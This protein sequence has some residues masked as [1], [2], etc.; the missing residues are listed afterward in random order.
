MSKGK[1]FA[2]PTTV[3]EEGAIIGEKSSIWHFTHIMAGAVIGEGC[4]I[5]Q[6]VFIGPNV[7]L[8]SNVKNG[9]GK[10][11]SYCYNLSHRISL[12]DHGRVKLHMDFRS[13]LL[14]NNGR[15]GNIMVG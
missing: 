7:H 9:T 12:K 4:N 14:T 3:I 2:H 6:N 8:G 1:Y 10:N 11:D 15:Y 13:D 5:G